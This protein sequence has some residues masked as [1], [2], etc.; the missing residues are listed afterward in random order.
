LPEGENYVSLAFGR[1]WSTVKK[2]NRL[3]EFI[4]FMIAF[5]VYNDGVIM[6]LN[7]AAIIG[8]VLFGMDQQMLIV[9]VIVVQVTNVIGAYAFG[10]LAELSLLWS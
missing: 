5:L 7:F 2:A 1:L 9:F 10:L 6:A 8:A 3:S 4:K